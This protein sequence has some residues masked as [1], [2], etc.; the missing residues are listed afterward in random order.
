MTSVH[1]EQHCS[2][3]MTK[4][5][6]E[7]FRNAAGNEYIDFIRTELI[8]SSSLFVQIKIH[9]AKKVHESDISGLKKLLLFPETWT[10]NRVG[11]S[12]FTMVL[13]STLS[14]FTR[15]CLCCLL[16]TF[17]FDK[18]GYRKNPKNDLDMMISS[19]N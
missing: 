15:F 19:W 6:R 4:S 7:C 13:I 10:K 8:S 14:Y 1:T 16:V 9:D 18:F 17:Y 12:V 3:M 5:L 2:Y 11:R